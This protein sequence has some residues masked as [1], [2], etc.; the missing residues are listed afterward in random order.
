MLLQ[1][2]VKLKS[3]GSRRPGPDEAAG[4]VELCPV[5]GLHRIINVLEVGTRFGRSY[6]KARLFGVGASSPAILSKEERLSR[7]PMVSWAG[8]MEAPGRAWMGRAALQLGI[9]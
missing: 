5:N 3:R 9:L 6:V 8:K 2:S 1:S 7:L 4:R